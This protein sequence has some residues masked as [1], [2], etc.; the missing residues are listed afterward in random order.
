MS[1]LVP[2]KKRILS[3]KRDRTQSVLSLEPIKPPQQA[4]TNSPLLPSTPTPTQTPQKTTVEPSPLCSPLTQTPNQDSYSCPICDKDLSS[5]RTSYQRQQHV[6]KCLDS[7]KDL[8]VTKE[9]SPFDYCIFCGKHISAL[10]S[11]RKDA[12]F[13]RCLDEITQEEKASDDAAKE[14]LAAK[15][16]PYL[17]SLDLCPCCYETDLFRTYRIRQKITHVKKCAKGRSIGL[18][19]LLQQCRWLGWGHTPLSVTQPPPPPSPLPPTKTS[20]KRTVNCAVVEDGSDDFKETVL[21]YRK[22]YPLFN[23]STKSDKSDESLQ[24]G[25]AL[26]LSMKPSIAKKKG[27][28]SEYDQN[29]SNI[30]TVEESRRVVLE[31]LDYI[32]A[33]LPHP[34]QD[35]VPIPPSKLKTRPIDE[36]RRSRCLWDLAIF[37]NNPSSNEIYTLNIIKPND[38]N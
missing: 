3:L 34:P 33:S 26:S 1:S 7:P 2:R 20:L 29:S 13:S 8:P 9:E 30:L 28:P 23:K 17:S 19:Q 11:I 4:P 22:P 10:N 18:P 15:E 21:M 24:T 6:N 38:D 31:S 16:A 14:A 27:R 37:R 35:L 25:L 5:T 32:L 12:H 36:G